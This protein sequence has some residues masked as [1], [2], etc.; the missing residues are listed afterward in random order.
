[1]NEQVKEYL[2]KYPEGVREIFLKIRQILFECAPGAR[3]ETWARMPSYYIGER[4]VRL[5]AFKDHINVEV[6]SA[7]VDKAAFAGYKITP[8]GM[9]QIFVGQDIPRDALRALFC[10]ALKE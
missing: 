1:M 3:E 7:T 5:I 4:F 9:I 6:G 2:E 8:K 10:A